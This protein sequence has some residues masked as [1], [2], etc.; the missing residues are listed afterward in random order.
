MNL[1]HRNM[2][3]IRERLIIAL[4]FIDLKNP[5]LERKT[6]IKASDWSSLRNRRVRANEDHLT[7]IDEIAPEFS[8]WIMTGRTIPDA[9]QI[10]PEI[11]ETRQ[12]LK[13]A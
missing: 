8:Y 5:A 13:R 3:D 11:E 10:S 4:D 7:A 2:Q 6:G 9:G 12:K 1:L